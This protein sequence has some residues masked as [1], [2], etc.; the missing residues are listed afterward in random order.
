MFTMTHMYNIKVIN[1]RDDSVKGLIFAVK[2]WLGLSLFPS[3]CKKQKQ[4]KN[5]LSFAELQGA[6]SGGF[7]GSCCQGYKK[8]QTLLI[9]SC[10][11]L[12]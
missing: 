8:Y 3:H 4:L 11:D 6:T 1:A 5:L 9:S 2:K 12:H 7:S 10:R